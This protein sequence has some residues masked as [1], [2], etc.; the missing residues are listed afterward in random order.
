MDFFDGAVAKA[1]AALDVACKKT[2]EAVTVQRQHFDI[3]SLEAKRAK[4]FEA[5]GRLYYEEIGNSA[6]ENGK[7]AELKAAIDEKNE[8]IEALRRELNEIKNKRLCPHCG[9]AV[10]KNAV[11][12]SACGEK[13]VYEGNAS[14]AKTEADSET[15]NR[16]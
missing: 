15:E 8:K 12:C 3:S 1:K 13:L 6:P 7:I 5:L 4:D 10:D 9:T 11:F 16:E 14:E 2:N